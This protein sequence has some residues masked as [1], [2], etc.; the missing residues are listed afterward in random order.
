MD[1]DHKHHHHHDAAVPVPE[2][3]Q[4]FC[5]VTGDAIDIAEAEKLGHYRDVDGKRIYFNISAGKHTQLFVA[6]AR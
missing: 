1:H 3:R 5:P 2:G 4:A 6:E